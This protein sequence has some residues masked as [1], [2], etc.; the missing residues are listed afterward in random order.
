MNWDLKCTKN[1]PNFS[2]REAAKT[3]ISYGTV[4]NYNEND[5]RKRLLR[6][7]LLTNFEFLSSPLRLL[8]ACNKPSDCHLFNY[9]Q[10][11][12]FSVIHNTF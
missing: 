9:D 3:R 12:S 2:V 4:T 5:M 1:S 11:F 6:Q 7:T 8:D 10:G